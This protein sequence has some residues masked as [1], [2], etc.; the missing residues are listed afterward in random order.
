[1]S[2]P[3]YARSMWLGGAYRNSCGTSMAAPV[4]TGVAALIWQKWPTWTAD[5]VGA[6]LQAAR[7]DLGASGRFRVRA[8]GRSF[9]GVQRLT[10]ERCGYLGAVG[11]V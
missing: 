6:R 5:N 4:I 7:V 10:V 1:M 11:C 2:A 9:C 3:F 8:R